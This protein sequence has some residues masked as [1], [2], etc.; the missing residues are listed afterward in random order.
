PAALSASNAFAFHF[1]FK[2]DGVTFTNGTLYNLISQFDTT[3]AHQ[4]LSFTYQDAVLQ[5]N[6]WSG[7]RGGIQ[8]WH[9]NTD[10]LTP[11]IGDG[12]WHYLEVVWTW[13]GTWG[14]GSSGALVYLDGVSASFT[15]DGYSLVTSLPASSPTHLILGNNGYWPAI[16]GMSVADFG[17]WN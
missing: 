12:L 8:V 10:I 16:V 17:L 9:S 2:L 15:H 7:S 1:A 6:I 5:L 3:A 11:L 14:Y 4:A 13:N